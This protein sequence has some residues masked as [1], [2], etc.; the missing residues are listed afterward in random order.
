MKIVTLYNHKGGVSK[1][2]TT[3][4]L[5]WLLAAQGKSVLLVDADPQCNLTELAL[6]STIE[7]LDAA[8]E[9]NGTE[10]QDLAGTS[11]RQI[12]EPRLQG[13]V[14]EIDVNSI[15]TNKVKENLE[16]IRGSVDLSE[17]E[18]EFA[19]AHV[20][21]FATKTHL[22][23]NYVALADM[24]Q[25]LAADRGYDYVFIDVG[26]SSGALTRACFLACD[27]FF[28]PVA[29]DRF[30]VQA[31]RTVSSIISRWIAEHAEIYD[32]YLSL[33][34]PV[35]P[36]KPVFLGAVVQ[37]FKVYRGR[38]KR[39]YQFWI[40]RIPERIQEYL[41]PSLGR[42]SSPARPLVGCDAEQC[43]AA[44]LPDFGTLA[45]LA[46]QLGK[47]V[48]AITQADTALVTEDGASWKGGTWLGAKTRI[49]D[50]R[51]RFENLAARLED[52]P[53]T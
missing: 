27:A 3:F 46:Q 48:Y 8:A 26:P 40:D 23:R 15:E 2:T 51:G 49:D 30:S 12:L 16:L 21:R 38:A 18:D 36:G 31:I 43:I 11:L 25:R 52:A 47:A 28:V 22:R 5:A 10:P 24:L 33:G 39:A 45:P 53:A 35:R 6:A 13:A 50:I 37:A 9:E 4:N 29:P 1:T 14:A 42:F 44:E 34:L 7:A 17:L 20:Q 41:V 32:D 19:E